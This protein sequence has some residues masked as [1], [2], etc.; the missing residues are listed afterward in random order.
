MSDRDP[1]WLTPKIKW[2]IIQK[3]RALRR[4]QFDKA[5]TFDNK[6]KSAKLWR[7]TQTGT[8]S[9]WQRVDTVTHRKITSNR[10]HATSFNP[11]QLNAELAARSALREGEVRESS[12]VFQL[13]GQA[14]PQLSEVE[15]A[16]VMKNCKRTSPGPSGIPSFI[17]NEYWDV[18]NAPYLHLWNSSLQRGVVPSVYKSADLIP[19]PKVR[20]AKKPNEVR[21]ISITPISARLFERAVHHKW[22]TPNIISVGDQYQF[23]Y[24]PKLSTIDCLLCLQHYILSMLDSPDVDGV[25]AALIDFSKAFDR[26]I[27]EKAGRKYHHFIDSSFIKRWLYDFT[28]NRK[29]RLIW[30]DEPLEYLPI[31]L[32][33]S[34]GTVGGPG[35]FSMYTDNLRPRNNT[36]RIFKYSDDTNCVSLCMK[37][38]TDSDKE[39]FSDEIQA[40]IDWA[41]ENGLNLNME[42]S[43]H[44]RFCLNR[45][46]H[47]ECSRK[48]EHFATVEHVKILG[49]T[50][51]TNCSFRKHC[52]RL[53][54]EFRSSLF[55]LKD[56]KING[57]STNDI[58]H[59]FESLVISRVRYGLSIFGSDSTSLK[60]IDK[61]LQKC[62]EKGYS[63]TKFDIM[64]LLQ[65]EDQRN[66]K[67]I[68]LN[69]NHPLHNYIIAYRK[70]RTTRHNFTSAKP[71]V[72]TRTFLASFANRVLPY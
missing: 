51:Q 58:H 24:K 4:R 49:I 46:P 44:V 19:I 8:K 34:Q 48:E 68:L 25:H 38:P 60:D 3:K 10:L 11:T 69:I 7:V 23:A 61:F 72:R 35:I 52:H 62:Y 9:W 37:N 70:P 20:N 18:L 63:K 30:K 41:I 28:V 50:F 71:R 5:Q 57:F 39:V 59:V 14:V 21:G 1:C 27:Q 31:D 43:K 36:S 12:P 56:L 64:E 29:Q 47:C 22:I 40:V 54:S 42:K 53:L 66:L 32:G 6:I 16:Q 2:A 65:E 26:V 55:L 45:I 67:N 33:C 15:V 17:F 13:S